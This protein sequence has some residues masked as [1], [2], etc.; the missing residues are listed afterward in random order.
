MPTK[1][2]NIY[3]DC[4]AYTGDTLD[5]KSLFN[6]D[7][8]YVIAFEANPNLYELLKTKKAD[9]IHNLAVWH[10]EETITFGIDKSKTPMGSTLMSSKAQYEEGNK[11]KI[12]AIDFAKFITKFKNDNLLV[13]M[14]IEGAEFPVLEHLIATGT[15]V[16]INKLYVE[17]HENKVREYTG[18]YR[19]DL[20]NRLKCG[21]VNIWH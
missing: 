10:K 5:C 2:K 15:D 21:E 4:G 14:D 11:V 18:I 13:K 7:A 6:F 16:Y 12:Q 9:E 20:I 8:D 19:N 3:I 17:T 1:V